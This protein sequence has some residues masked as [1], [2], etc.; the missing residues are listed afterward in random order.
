MPR[1]TRI[2]LWAYLAFNLLIA[3]TLILNPAQV[4]ET[5]RGGTMT[6][7]REFLWFS[8]GSFHLLVVGLT[9]VVLRL[10]RAAERRWIIL[11]NAAFYLWD[12]LTEWAYW[13]SHIGVAPL[14]LHRNA[15]LSALCGVLLVIG[16]WWDHQA[17]AA[18]AAHGGA[19]QTTKP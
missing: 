4:D 16:C 2:I 14:A 10:P 11:L 1:L 13:G 7:T 8:I 17:A 9:L 6:A 12:A 3:L 5:Y 18:P 19:A 15:G